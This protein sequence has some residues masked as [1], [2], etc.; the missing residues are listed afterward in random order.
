MNALPRLR[1]GLRAGG[2]FL[3]VALAVAAIRPRGEEAFLLRDGDRVVFYG[4]SI[5]EA[6]HYTSVVETYVF[7]RFPKLAVTFVHSG[8]NGDDAQGGE[9]GQ[10]DLRLTRD[11]LAHEPTVVTI[12]LGMNDG[13]VRP[14]DGRL[15]EAYSQGYRHIVDTLKRQRPGIR[16]TVLRPSP[17]DDVTR[18]PDFD[19]GYNAVLVR[20]GDFL[21][22]LAA[23][24]GL[25]VAD[26]NG[27][28]VKTLARAKAADPATAARLIS[29]R[30]HPGPQ[31]TLVMAQALLRAWNAPALVSEVEIDAARKAA[32]LQLNSQVA[33]IQGGPALSWSQ[34]DG[35]L[36]MPLN[37]LDPLVALV[38]RSSDFMTA[39]NR[40][41]LRIKGLPAGHYTLRIDG[42]RAG[43]FGADSLASG[44]N[45]AELPT[46]MAKQAAEVHALTLEHNVLHWWAWRR[47]QVAFAPTPS[48]ELTEAVRALGALEASMIRRK[49]EVA[50]PKPRRFVLK[51]EAVPNG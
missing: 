3:A 38:L 45:L 33:D 19:G 9:G 34:T 14:F 2:A 13:G 41:P 50:Q 32:T 48:P 31:I 4:D 20:Y 40:Q 46:P 10:I 17:Y 27:P 1:G 11:V 49:R 8:W 43:T 30:I 44:I 28:V 16:I 5:T 51:P 23:R 24:E 12:M 21:E 47:I 26:L 36:P 42:M 7:T 15:F 6:R 25:T 18:P 22:E 35:A 39:L 37:L 29:D